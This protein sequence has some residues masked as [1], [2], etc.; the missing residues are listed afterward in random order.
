MRKSTAL[1]GLLKEQY[2][3]QGVCDKEAADAAAKQ[4][5]QEMETQDATHILDSIAGGTKGDTLSLADR[6]VNRSIGSQ[7]KSRIQALKDAVKKAAAR[8]D[9]K[10]NVKLEPC[11]GE[12]TS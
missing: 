12:P 11:N 8:G 3:A 9:K 1:Y 5:A 10:M 2:L 6:S 4:T 7:W